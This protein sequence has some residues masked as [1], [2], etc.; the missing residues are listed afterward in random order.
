MTERLEHTLILPSV[1][2]LSPLRTN[3]PL[4]GRGI[5]ARKQDVGS[6]LQQEVGD[7]TSGPLTHGLQAE[8]RQD[9]S[10]TEAVPQLSHGCYRAHSQSIFRLDF[11]QQPNFHQ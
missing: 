8:G 1:Q 10:V 3:E 6:Q 4:V 9:H 7:P 2:T 11:F 5:E